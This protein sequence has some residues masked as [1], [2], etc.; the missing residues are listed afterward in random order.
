MT[1]AKSGLVQG[2][3]I[4]RCRSAIFVRL[5]GELAYRRAPET[6]GNALVAVLSNETPPR[7]GAYDGSCPIILR[8]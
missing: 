6:Y 2:K 4:C 8:T 1:G 5:S 3:V 7:I